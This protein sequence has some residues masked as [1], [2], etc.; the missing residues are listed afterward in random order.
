MSET[1]DLSMRRAEAKIFAWITYREAFTKKGIS[2]GGHIYEF[3]ESLA[4]GI[5]GVSIS[6]SVSGYLIRCRGRYHG[7]CC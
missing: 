7:G 3:A 1:A 6:S 4:I 5:H 2:G